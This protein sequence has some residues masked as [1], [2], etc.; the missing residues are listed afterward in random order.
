MKRPDPEAEGSV[1]EKYDQ[2][3]AEGA[4]NR[5]AANSKTI[6]FGKCI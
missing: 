6:S 3:Q 2:Q 5:A 4:Q 1:K